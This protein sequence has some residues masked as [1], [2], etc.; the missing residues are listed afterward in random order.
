MSYPE[1]GNSIH[2]HESLRPLSRHHMVALLLALNLRKVGTEKSKSTAKEMQ[3]ELKKFWLPG[4]QEHFRE[5]EEILLTAYAQHADIDIPEVQDMLMEH[6]KIRAL[7]DA[8]LKMDDIEISVMHQLG[9]LLDLHI[10]KEE[11]ILFPM[12]EQALP[13]DVLVEIAPYLE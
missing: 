4:G 3:V 9:E 11:R 10:R 12:I 5:E 6:V 1:R 7:I 8:L 2:R 13:E